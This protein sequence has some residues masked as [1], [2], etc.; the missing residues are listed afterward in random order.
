MFHK[1]GILKYSFV[2]YC[3]RWEGGGGQIQIANFGEKT[4]QVNQLLFFFQLLF[5]ELLFNKVAGLR[6]QKISNEYR[7]IECNPNKDI[8]FGCSG[9]LELYIDKQLYCISFYPTKSF[10]MPIFILVHH[11]IF[12]TMSPF[13]NAAELSFQHQLQKENYLLLANHNYISFYDNHAILKSLF[14]ESS[15]I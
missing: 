9:C 15:R 8:F 1:I 3:R 10:C 13:S 7:F 2:P 11:E 6:L 12:S 5:T 4:P 14:Q